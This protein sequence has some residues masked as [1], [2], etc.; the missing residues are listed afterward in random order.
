MPSQ[1]ASSLGGAGFS[2]CTFAYVSS[3]AHAGQLDKACVTF[4]KMLTCA[5]HLGVYS[6]EIGL[7]GE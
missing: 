6:E 2:L 4:E 5:N 3:L 1:P 7:T